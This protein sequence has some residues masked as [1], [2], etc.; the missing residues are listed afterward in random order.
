MDRDDIPLLPPWDKSEPSP[1]AVRLAAALAE[2]LDVVVPR[3]FHVR[4][5]GGWIA[6]YRGEE[7]DGSTGV[8]AIVG[9]DDAG[10]E[11]IADKGAPLAERV[12]AAAWAVLSSVQDAVSEATTEPWPVL[13]AGGLALPGTRAD[14]ESVYLWF[15]PETARETG[16]VLSLPSIRLEELA[17]EP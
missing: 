7:W 17:G 13:P 8:A 2:R 14:D 10:P 5:E 11:G 6:V 16:A 3:P 15:G 1:A 4:A 12:Q 9:D